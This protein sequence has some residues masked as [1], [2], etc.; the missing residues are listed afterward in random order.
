MASTCHITIVVT[1]KIDLGG[2]WVVH[3]LHAADNTKKQILV[4]F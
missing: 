2:Q 1:F 3:K 4:L